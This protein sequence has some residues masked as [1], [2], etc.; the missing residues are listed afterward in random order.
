MAVALS[1]A[2]NF[3]DDHDVRIVGR[4][5]V[6]VH[7]NGAKRLLDASDE[8]FAS[9]P[10]TVARHSRSIL[11]G[12]WRSPK[13]KIV[14]YPDG[15]LASGHEYLQ[16]IVR[17][18]IPAKLFFEQDGLKQ[19]ELKIVDEPPSKLPPMLASDDEATMV[20]TVETI[21]PELANAYLEANK[22]N[23]AIRWHNVAKYASD[24]RAGNW[25]LTH[26]GIGF[27]ADGSLADGQHRLKAIVEADVAVK[28]NVTRGLDRSAGTTLD[29]HGPRNDV[30]LM[31]NL[32]IGSQ[33]DRYVVAVANAMRSNGTSPNGRSSRQ[34]GL[35]FIVRH[36]EAIKFAIAAA[37]TA[38]ARS[39]VFRGVVARAFYTVD[40]QILCRFSEVVATGQSAGNHESA[41]VAI[42]NVAVRG[43]VLS[44]SAQR[45]AYN[46]KI[47]NALQ[48]FICGKPLSKVH[49][50]KEVIFLLPEEVG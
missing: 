35:R 9:L 21:T 1:F 6:L 8:Q 33:V 45:A 12:E 34:E 38:E 28:M 43:N 27:Y 5:V 46:L 41:A 37:R 7:P 24:M 23:R 17:A 36:L 15:S 31:S 11:A 13:H 30:D 44:S 2:G 3:D 18:G 16:G 42:R 32:D 10:S 4:G 22:K 26:Q 20:T 25:K 39:S 14:L 47:Q 50:A 48:A 19:A 49:E 40:H 29:I